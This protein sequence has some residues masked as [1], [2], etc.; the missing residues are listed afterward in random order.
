MNYNEWYRRNTPDLYYT[1][2][3]NFLDYFGSNGVVAVDSAF[4]ILNNAFTNNPTGMT[5]GL[6]GYSSDLSEFPLNSEQVNYTA[7]SAGL[8]DVKSEVLILLM[9]QLG[10]A[11]SIRYTWVIHDRFIPVGATCLVGTTGNGVE[12]T[13]AMRNFDIIAS[14]LNGLQYT[15]YVNGSL[16]AY[17]VYEV[18]DAPSPRSPPTVDAIEIPVDP[19]TANPPVASGNGEEPLNTGVFYTGLTRDDVG[20]MR[21]LYSSSRI[22]VEATAP[23]SVLVS[24]SGSSGSN[25]GAPF[26]LSTS[27]YTALALAAQ[28]TDPITLATLFPGLLIA[29][30]TNF[31]SVVLVPNF[32]VITNNVIGAPPGTFVLVLTTNAPTPTIVTN[33]V[34]TF[35][36]VVVV[37]N[38][39]FHTNSSATLLTVQVKEK[40]GQPAGTLQTNVTRQYLTLTNVP[41]GDYYISTNPCGPNVILNPQP[42]GFPLTNVTA[43][44]NLIVGA[45]TPTGLSFT[46]SLVIYLTNHLYVAQPLIC[47]V[48]TTGAQANVTGLYE[49]IQKMSFFQANFDSLLGQFFQPIT[50]NYTMVFVTNFQA[51]LQN[52]QRVVTQPDF[53]FTAVDFSPGPEQGSVVLPQPVRRNI[54]FNNSTAGTGL[55]GPATIVSPTTITLNTAGPIFENQSPSYLNGP[56]NPYDRSFI[57]GSFDGTTND[58]IVYPN[59]TS[60]QNL[61]NQ[62]LI[63]V[64]PS[65]L[66]VPPGTNNAVYTP[67]TFTATGGA[68]TPPYTWTATGLPPELTLSP[69]GTL[70]G[71]PTQSGSFVFVLQL[72]DVLGRSVQ[73][74]YLIVIN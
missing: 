36:N 66:N 71:I 58:P 73:W 44:T 49:G 70:S 23:G 12:Y 34:T 18:C 17:L 39:N 43:V 62:V 46:Q 19:L 24:S 65:S 63:Q 48:V 13:I 47:G 67:T 72:T 56:V 2:D 33:Y 64:T 40:I 15:P 29:S 8:L 6:D 74:N 55:A 22:D 31:F 5:N 45:S 30:S 41:S 42:P 60:V 50:N 26:V 3:A 38:N 59:G 57:W 16:F 20:G 37:T 51:V 52:F 54:N 27:N 11:D 28:T 61:I 21:Y 7:Q 35:A 68:F 9:E 10:L 4:D 69:A 53:L 14:P 1:F 25:L 32:V